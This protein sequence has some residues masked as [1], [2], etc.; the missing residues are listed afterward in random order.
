M[1]QVQGE[2]AAAAITP[3]SEK[4]GDRGRLGRS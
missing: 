4:K 2:E 3:G 1:E